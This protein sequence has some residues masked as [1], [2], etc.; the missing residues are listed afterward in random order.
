MRR[1][2]NLLLVLAVL[3]VTFQAGAWYSQ[4]PT[5]SASAATR[6]VLHYVCPMHPGYVSAEPGTAPCCGMRL[7]PVYADGGGPA[8][9]VDDLPAGTIGVTP[10][11]QRLAGIQVETVTTGPSSGTLRLPGRVVPDERR[12][13]SLNAGLDGTIRDVSAVTT[14]SRVGKH[15]LLATYTAPDFLLAVQAYILALEG[16]ERLQSDRSRDAASGAAT[17]GPPTVPPI[18]SRGEQGLVVSS[19]SSNFQQRLDRLHL[20]GMS[21]VQIEEIRRMRDVPASIK[22]V[23]PVEGTI[24]ARRI[25][26]GWKFMRGEEWFRIADLRRVWVVVDVPGADVAHVREGQAVLVRV[27]GRGRT[28]TARTSDVAPLFDASTRTFKVRLELDN[29]DEVLRPD[30]LV[31]VEIAIAARPATTVPLDAV[32][33]TGLKKTVYVER[34]PGTFEPRLVET[35]WRRAD[36][37][38]V[39]HGLSPGD[40]IVTSGTFLLD[41]ETRMRGG[42]VQAAGVQ[43][44]KDPVCGMEVNVAEATAASLSHAREGGTHYFCSRPCKEQFVHAADDPVK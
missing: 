11:Q 41:S 37:V 28:L 15:Q 7:E 12:V 4:G 35:G 33:D 23:S 16:L 1:A 39:V 32:I 5:A 21:D 10:W 38:E 27:P 36:R 17:P 29:P 18:I 31:D 19:G 24:L 43:G 13:F 14:G 30:M 2:V 22:I 42:P 44:V 8:S 3:A 20:L 25:T 26:P 6:K 9:D 34:S 40:R